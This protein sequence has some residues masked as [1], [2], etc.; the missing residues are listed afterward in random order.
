MLEVRS[1]R[2]GERF[3]PLGMHGRSAS[4][5]DVMVNRKLPAA[6]RSR[7]PLVV[8]EAHPLWLVG[9]Q[10]DERAKVTKAT[11]HIVQLRCWREE[12]N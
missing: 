1:R 12:N 4:I 7:W 8:T 10:M 9:L 11:R 3:Q 6:L 5:Q 2:P